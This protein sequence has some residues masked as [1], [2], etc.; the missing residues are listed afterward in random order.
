MVDPSPYFQSV[1][2]PVNSW[3]FGR[4]L[5]ID[6][7]GVVSR[8][9][10]DCV[11]CQLG[12]IEVKTSDRQCFVPTENI[13][14]DL[15]T[16]APWEVDWITLSGSGE[17]TLALNLGELLTMVAEVT[18]RSTA[19]LTNGTL[20]HDP[21]VRAELAIADA[22]AV[23]LDA[24]SP[25]MWRRISRPV[26]ALAW[27]TQWAGLQAFRQEYS[28]RLLVQTMLLS[29]WSVADQDYYLAQMNALRPDEIQLNTPTRP[30]PLNHQLDARGNHTPGEPDYPV[31][32][33]KPVTSQVLEGF[34]D[35]LWNATH[36]PVRVPDLTARM[37][38]P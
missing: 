9:S 20:L 3:R 5:G 38:A 34:R 29:P 6:P 11:Y 7:I 24:L 17:P 21:Q 13:R 19:V 12:E 35:R 14:H 26:D 4:S 30:K 37:P 16:Y 31:R 2:G 8:C 15:Q 22:V 28:G 23:K 1:Y 18:R 33:L 10:L 27:S 36:I 25:D 32:S